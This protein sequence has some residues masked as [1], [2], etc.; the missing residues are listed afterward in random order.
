MQEAADQTGE[1][2]VT[3]VELYI[4]LAEATLVSATPDDQALVQA[5]SVPDSTPL[6]KEEIRYFD[7]E[8]ESPD[9]PTTFSVERLLKSQIEEFLDNIFPELADNTDI[10]SELVNMLLW[11]DIR[12]Q[13][14]ENMVTMIETLGAV[15]GFRD[16][17]IK[18]RRAGGVKCP[19]DLTSE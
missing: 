14:F 2:A 11:K 4:Q 18:Y 7:E 16:F 10:W 1:V 5:P 12:L 17:E 9:I 3:S 6:N 19:T 15:H 13:L 8:F